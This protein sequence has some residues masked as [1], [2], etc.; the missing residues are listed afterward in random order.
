ML[1][2][3]RI[4]KEV[5]KEKKILGI[6]KTCDKASQWKKKSIIECKNNLTEKKT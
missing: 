5:T 3:G 6:T 1:K 4:M 2:M